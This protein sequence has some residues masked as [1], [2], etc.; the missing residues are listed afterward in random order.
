LSGLLR[1]Q[2]LQ[3]AGL[4]WGWKAA[5][6]LDELKGNDAVVLNAVW[7]LIKAR[8]SAEQMGKMTA[9]TLNYLVGY[10]KVATLR[11]AKAAQANQPVRGNF[12][13]DDDTI[14]AALSSDKNVKEAKYLLALL[15]DVFLAEFHCVAVDNNMNVAK[16]KKVLAFSFAFLRGFQAGSV[17]ASDDIFL[18]AYK[19]GLQ[20]W[21]SGRLRKRLC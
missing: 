1:D 21:I 9:Y 12:T 2:N 10:V 18:V 20:N 7:K 11:A 15:H 4:L 14:L 19:I 17:K 16:K 13:R 5:G 6:E 3:A 8:F